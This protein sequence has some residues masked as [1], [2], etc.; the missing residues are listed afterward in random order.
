M[1]KLLTILYFL[2]AICYMM[3]CAY[4]GNVNLYSPQGEGI[5]VEKTLDTEIDI[6]LLP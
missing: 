4:K 2:Y 5:A 6:P 1:N 3:G